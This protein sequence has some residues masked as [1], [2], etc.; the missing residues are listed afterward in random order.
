MFVDIN[1]P[2]LNLIV[3]TTLLLMGFQNF[4]RKEWNS[5]KKD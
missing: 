4:F 3:L 1:T 2:S 5:S